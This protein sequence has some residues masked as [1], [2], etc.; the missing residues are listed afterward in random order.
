MVRHRGIHDHGACVRLPH[1]QGAEQ[2]GQAIA[3]VP[4]ILPVDPDIAPLSMY[5][6]FL[7]PTLYSRKC[8]ENRSA[9]SG[10]LAAL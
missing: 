1:Q 8:A 5:A 2:V 10:L 9:V 3:S 6:S 7:L 4:A